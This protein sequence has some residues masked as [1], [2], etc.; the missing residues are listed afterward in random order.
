MMISC[1]WKK[2]SHYVR[3]L[4]ALGICKFKI[5]GGEPLVR[6]NAVSFIKKLKAM[7]GVEQVT[8]TTNGLELGASAA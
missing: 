2:C 8:I 1:G 5:T 4:L 3:A 7:P 6:W